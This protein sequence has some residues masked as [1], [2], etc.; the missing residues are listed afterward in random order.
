MEAWLCVLVLGLVLLIAQ[1]VVINL[2][3]KPR[4]IQNYFLKQGIRGPKYNF[5]LGNFKEMKNFQPSSDEHF[6]LSHDIVRKVF[7]FYHHWKN[8]YGATFLVWFGPIARVI[9]ADPSLIKDIFFLQLNNFEK[10]E[11]PS[12]AK[13]IDGDGLLNLKGEKWARHRKILTPAFYSANLKLMIPIIGE[14]MK[15][16]LTKWSS[17][18]SND[19]KVEIEVSKW[20]VRLLE[21][22]IIHALFGRNYEEY[23][24]FIFKL[25][26]QQKVYATKAYEQISIPGYRFLPTKKNIIA[27]RLERD[28]RK[29][30]MKLIEHRRKRLYCHDDHD[31]QTEDGPKDLLEVM[32]K[33]SSTNPNICSL[34]TGIINIDE[35]IDE[36]KTIFF[37]AKY[38]TSNMLTWT[39]ILLAMNP[40]WQELARDEV[41]KVCG[42]RD[43]PSKDDIPKLST[44]GMILNESL[45]LYPPVAAAIR[46]AKMDTKLGGL[47]LPKGT[48]VLIPIIGIHHDATLWGEDVNEFNPA[49]FAHGVAQAPKSPMA[50]MPFGL[51]ARHCIGQNLAIIEAKVVMS[52]ILMR[53][54]FQLAP[55]YRHAPAIRL[56]LCP[57][58]GAPIIFQKL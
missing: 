13:K 10:I 45:R 24:K 28:V 25:Q 12:F 31:I 26:A 52:M 19:D 53:F 51:G 8:I 43:A 17:K 2:Y 49:R 15:D 58:H 38:S 11:P 7:S 54:S 55:T 39:T 1:K 57:Q 6:P 48:E 20:F 23:G 16:M 4:K 30:F 41:F 36:C 56:F 29:T 44:L 14:N 22:V 27:W 3:W 21:D 35:I 34:S 47:N 18:I 32:I 50:F 42:A 5:L 37:A 46:Q 33:T 9:I 40:H